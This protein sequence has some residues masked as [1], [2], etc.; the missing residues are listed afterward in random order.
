M[1]KVKFSRNFFGPDGVQYRKGEH[2]V[3]DAWVAE[4]ANVLP[5]TAEVLPEADVKAKPA[6]KAAE[7]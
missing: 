6:A 5:K 3:P 7:K 1:A 4:D 2:N